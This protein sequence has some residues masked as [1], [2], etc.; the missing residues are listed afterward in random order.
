MRIRGIRS[1][2]RWRTLCGVLAVACI[3]P[4]TLTFAAAPA[5]AYVRITE[6]C[7]LRAYEP[8]PF[9]DG[10]FQYAG[11]VDCRGQGEYW[12]EV[13]VCAEVQNT[14]SGLWYRIT[15]SCQISGPSF[16]EYNEDAGDHDGICGVNYRTWDRGEVFHG[17]KAKREGSWGGATYMS[18]AVKNVC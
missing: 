11:A 1:P 3:A 7:I 15:G 5:S 17:D 9:E 16:R 14:V 6:H 4:A 8:L 10:E 2:V 18:S 12:T 13:E